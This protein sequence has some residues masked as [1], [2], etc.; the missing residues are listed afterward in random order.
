MLRPLKEA[1]SLAQGFERRLRGVASR[2]LGGG[3]DPDQD[4]QGTRQRP[5]HRQKL[6][7]CV[8]GL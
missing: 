6:R 5:G 7:R 4:R 2:S 1:Q 8:C 3:L